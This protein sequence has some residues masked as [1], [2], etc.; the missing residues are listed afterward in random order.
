MLAGVGIVS[1][2][3]GLAVQDTLKDIIRGISIISE[4]YF[5]IGDYVT[6]GEHSGTVV[7]PGIR[8]TKIKDGLTGNVISIANR[9]IEKAEVASN[10][11]NLD[12]PLPYDLKLSKAEELMNEIVE[13]AKELELVNVCEYR[14][15]NELDDSCI[16]Y[17]LY[18]ETKR[19]ERIQA[20]RDIL[21]TALTVME[22]RK[23]SV[24]FPQLDI[25]QK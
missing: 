3:V 15:V 17:R 11:L 9:N 7:K 5:K 1:V 16:K 23:V 2:V 14:G 20:K 24:P 8:S 6:I 10:V 4:D 19:G 21:G 18:A 25:H 12:I 22:E 13:R